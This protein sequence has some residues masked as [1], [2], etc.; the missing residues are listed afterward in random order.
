MFFS[1]E[2]AAESIIL[3]NVDFSGE[4]KSKILET[5]W[6]SATGMMQNEFLVSFYMQNALGTTG[7]ALCITVDTQNI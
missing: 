7:A 1:F 6:V 5:L 4:Y 2:K 3:R